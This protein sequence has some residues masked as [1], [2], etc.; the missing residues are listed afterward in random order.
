V[1]QGSD[2]RGAR[3]CAGIPPKLEQSLQQGGAFVFRGCDAL[4]QHYDEGT[5]AHV[6]LAALLAAAGVAPAPQ[7]TLE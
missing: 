7:R 1:R 3:A 5:G 6:E 4:L 2:A